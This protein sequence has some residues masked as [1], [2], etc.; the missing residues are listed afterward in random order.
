MTNAI[1]K[2]GQH[3]FDFNEGIMSFMSP[4]QVFIIAVDNKDEEVEKSGWVINIHPDFLWN[5][6][7]AMSFIKKRIGLR[8]E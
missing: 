4:K 2:Y 7:L 1:L 8:H 3:L 6:P 5:T